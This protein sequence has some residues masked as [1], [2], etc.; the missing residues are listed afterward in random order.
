MARD[1]SL[2]R[3]LTSVGTQPTTFMA[4]AELELDHRLLR[5]DMV[6]KE[7]ALRFRV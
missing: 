3:E 2:L 6:P 5:T 1:F 4:S 7:L